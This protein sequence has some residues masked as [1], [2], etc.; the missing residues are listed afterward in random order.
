MG[1]WDPG[2][3]MLR[4]LAAVSLCVAAY[5]ATPTVS[6]ELRRAKAGSYPEYDRCKT[7]EYGAGQWADGACA[8]GKSQSPIDVC[9]ATG[10]L[11]KK[12]VLS[13]AAGYGKSHTV[14]LTPSNNA[15]LDFSKTEL[16]LSASNVPKIVGYADNAPTWKLVQ[17]HFHWGRDN[18]DGYWWRRFCDAHGHDEER[19]WLLCLCRLAHDSG[20]QRGRDLDQPREAARHH[21]GHPEQ[22]PCNRD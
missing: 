7:Q 20:L 11:D 19:R 5:A 2:V 21:P 3:V 22:V 14:K 17:A 6:T 15:Y 9:G 16:L 10:E 13:F 18:H 8:T 1:T 12:E 4:R